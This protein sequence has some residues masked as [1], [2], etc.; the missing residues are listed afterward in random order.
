MIFLNKG[1]NFTER[2]IKK[3]FVFFLFPKIKIKY[4]LN[5]YIHNKVPSK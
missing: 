2:K 3:G 5:N 4:Y 1:T